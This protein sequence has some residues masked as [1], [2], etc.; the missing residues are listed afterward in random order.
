MALAVDG[1]RRAGLIEM[2]VQ[3]GASEHIRDPAV[4]GFSVHDTVGGQQFDAYRLGQFD[5]PGVEPTFAAAHVPLDFDVHVVGAESL[6][7]RRTALSAVVRS[8]RN[9]A[10]MSGPSSSPVRQNV[11][12]GYLFEFIPK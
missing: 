12:G 3:T 10:L 4:G 9:N 6:T 1:Q 5:Q 2:R 7:S 8:P 11:L